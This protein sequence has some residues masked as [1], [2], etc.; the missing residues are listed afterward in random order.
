[1]QDPPI[2]AVGFYGSDTGESRPTWQ[3]LS[4]LVL[5][6]GDL[7]TVGRPAKRTV[8]PISRRTWQLLAVAS[9]GIHD[10]NHGGPGGSVAPT[11]EGEAP[12]IWR[13][14]RPSESPSRHSSQVTTIPP[15]DPEL[16]EDTAR[17]PAL[18]RDP[19]TI[20]RPCEAGSGR[21]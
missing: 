16:I 9:V 4:E 13:P 14:R 8:V 21:E 6:E 18:K 19:V 1:V 15:D 12:A 2:A 17:R 10:V 3:V 20:R 7:R 5:D 11:H